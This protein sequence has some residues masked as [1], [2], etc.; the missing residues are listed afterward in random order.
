MASPEL[1]SLKRIEAILTLN[2]DR[3]AFTNQLLSKM[4]A[5]LESIRDDGIDREL[6]LKA[7]DTKLAHIRTAMNGI[8]YIAGVRGADPD[9]M[10]VREFIAK[11]CRDD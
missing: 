8:F 9:P 4:L 1:E 10:E 3:I 7:I 11:Y 5:F 2:G 6:A